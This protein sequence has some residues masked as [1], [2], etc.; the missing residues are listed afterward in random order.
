MALAYEAHFSDGRTAARRKVSVRLGNGIMVIEPESGDPESRTLS[1]AFDDLRLADEIRPRRPIRLLN[2]AQS[3][4]RL[5]FADD[6]ILEDL[7]AKAPHLR[8][9]GVLGR[10]PG[11]R[12]LQWAA[13]VAAVIAILAIGLPNAAEPI[14]A[15]MPLA[16]EEAIGR[17]VIGGFQQQH[18]FCTNREGVVALVRLVVRLKGVVKSRYK[19][20]ITVAN[21]DSVNAF[22]A[23]GGYLV[24]NKGLIATARSPDEV[25]GVLAHEMGHVVESHATEGIVRAAGLALFVQLLLGDPSGALGIGVATGELLLSLA[26]NREDEAEADAVAVAILAAAGID[27][28]GFAD[29]LERMSQPVTN[30]E[31]APDQTITEDSGGGEAGDIPF[32]STH[33]RSAERAAIVRATGKPGGPAL[34]PA[35]WKS[36][37]KICEPAPE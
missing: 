35:D 19:F 37:R 2:A 4:A 1:W 22:A 32:L 14:A 26:Y 24:L 25:A 30:D 33:P 21:D 17:K 23:P 36:L 12:I 6:S 7:L 31:T 5:T 27:S 18:G 29:F 3:D 20:R 9:A 28:A 13:G 11:L 15:M 10:R 16:W 8:A 34:S